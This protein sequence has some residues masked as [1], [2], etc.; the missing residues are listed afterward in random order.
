MASPGFIR[1]IRKALEPG[2][3]SLLWIDIRYGIEEWVLLK[4]ARLRVKYT[5]KIMIKPDGCMEE[6]RVD[7]G[8][9][10]TVMDQWGL[11]LPLG[12]MISL[13]KHH[14]E[15]NVWNKENGYPEEPYE[16]YREADWP[17]YTLDKDVITEYDV[18]ACLRRHMKLR[19]GDKYY[20]K[21]YEYHSVHLSQE[22]IDEEKKRMDEWIA[23]G[24]KPYK[25][26]F[27]DGA[28]EDMKDILGD[29]E[30][31][32]LFDKVDLDN[33]TK[34]IIHEVTKPKDTPP[35]VPPEL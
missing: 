7:S 32:K 34:D 15:E 16:E 20:T 28:K 11:W 4:T 22:W 17:C 9:D 2:F 8:D 19:L 31:Q 24:R 12:F 10:Y 1:R 14:D 30:A 27:A 33:K 29:D 6:G 25:V 5:K 35:D 13:K 3:F 21:T 18:V 23:G 26:V